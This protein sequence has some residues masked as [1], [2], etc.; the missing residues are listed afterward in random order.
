MFVKRF[1]V[2]TRLP[3]SAN[4]FP[5][6]YFDKTDTETIHIVRETEVLRW[7]WYLILRMPIKI[8]GGA[9]VLHGYFAQVIRSR[10]R[11]AACARLARS[12]EGP[13]PHT[14]TMLLYRLAYDLRK[15]RSLVWLAPAHFP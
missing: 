6:S 15:I 10:E 12:C 9:D 11:E 5:E 1:S 14:S 3:E 7:L 8:G 13:M 4:L 2:H